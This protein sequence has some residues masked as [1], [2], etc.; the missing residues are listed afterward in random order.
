MRIANI[1]AL[2]DQVSARNL[3]GLII[4]MAFVDLEIIKTR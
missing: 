4:Y 1:V 3:S 2:W